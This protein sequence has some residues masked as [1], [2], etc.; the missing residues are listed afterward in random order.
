MH[1]GG[2]SDNVTISIFDPTI[3]GDRLVVVVVVVV[4]LI[5]HITIE[6]EGWRGQP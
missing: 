4:S 2:L 5:S 1:W 6:R 3:A